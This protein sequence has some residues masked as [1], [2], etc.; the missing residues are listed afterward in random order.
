MSPGQEWGS[1][2]GDRLLG[3][4]AG[5]PCV[6]IPAWRDFLQWPHFLRQPASCDYDDYDNTAMYMRNVGVA[7]C[8]SGAGTE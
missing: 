1:G 2:R 7:A 4:P 5:R 6:L 8:R 3:R